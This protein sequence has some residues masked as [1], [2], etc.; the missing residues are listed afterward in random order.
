[1]QDFSGTFCCLLHLYMFKFIK[2]FIT[3]LIQIGWL[4][5]DAKKTETQ[6]VVP[7]N[8]MAAVAQAG[9]MTDEYS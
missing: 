1:M 4:H 6:K 7:T 3:N 2:S 8:K 9:H 5:N